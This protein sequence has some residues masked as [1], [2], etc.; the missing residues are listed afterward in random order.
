VTEPRDPFEHWLHTE[1]EHLPPPPGTFDQIRKR[2]RRRKVRRAAISAASAG[3]AAGVVVLAVVALPKVVPSVLH[4]KSNPV[5][6]AAAGG[7]GHSYDHGATP[8][9]RASALPSTSPPASTGATTPGGPVPDNFAPTS[10][11]FVSLS[12]AFVI[13]Q[14]G[15]PGQCA[16]RNPYICT[17]IAETANAGQTWRGLPAPPTGAPD[18]STGVSQIRFIDPSTGWA[19][20]PELWV[21]H[22]GGH[23]WTQV[24]THGLRV[25]GLETA[26]GEAYAVFA[27]CSGTGAAFAASCKHVWLYSAPVDSTDWTP[28]TSGLGWNN[29]YVSAKVVLGQAQGAAP[30]GYF[31]EPDG[32]V[33][34]GPVTAGSNWQVTG[35]SPAPCQPLGAQH[36][37]QPAG[38]QL[39]ATGNGGLA[40]ACPGLTGSSQETVYTSA[41]GGQSW[42]Q[43]ATFTVSGSATSLADGSGVLMLAT[44][45]GVYTSSDGGQNWQE[46]LH[47]AAGGFSYV[48][49][50]SPTQA[51]AVPADPGSYHA[52]WM[53]TDGGQTWSQTPVTNG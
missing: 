5:S 6:H 15:T 10:V 45:G 14:A 29:G 34:T 19:F 43:Q 53:T 4:L 26:G 11:T 32:M 22:D 24:D 49:Q 30:Q 21:T 46:T 33:A 37:G 39:A 2:A 23:S 52:V 38:G 50:T 42:Q 16:D 25:T 1:V 12:T 41:D 40:L 17:S 7:H 20:G 18:G 28:M 47:T 48:G 13:G 44:T 35:Q 27:R 36:D 51:V 3:V 9:T 31:Y 8:T